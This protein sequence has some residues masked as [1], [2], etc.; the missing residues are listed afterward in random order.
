LYLSLS[1]AH[2]HMFG[3]EL[4]RRRSVRWRWEPWKTFPL[5]SS[6]RPTPP[7]SNALARSLS[8]SLSTFI[9]LYVCA[10]SFPYR[11]LCMLF[12]ASEPCICC[13]FFFLIVIWERCE[14]SYSVLHDCVNSFEELNGW[15]LFGCSWRLNLSI[16]RKDGYVLGND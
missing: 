12:Y 1:R 16:L 6:S 8:L 14:A 7:T 11:S 10:I 9:C 15:A 3:R 4:R 5:T 13:W 2:A